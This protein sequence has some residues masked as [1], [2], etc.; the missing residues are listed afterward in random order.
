MGRLRVRKQINGTWC[1]RTDAVIDVNVELFARGISDLDHL[2]STIIEEIH[3]SRVVRAG[4][5]HGRNY[6]D[7][8]LHERLFRVSATHAQ[9]KD[10]TRS[11][12]RPNEN[13]L[14]Y[15]YR[16]R[17]STAGRMF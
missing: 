2:G 14:S 12:H 4:L 9:C 16:N 15:G 11:P 8:A 6:S 3:K 13:K 10:D 1:L 7:A 17:A 5:A